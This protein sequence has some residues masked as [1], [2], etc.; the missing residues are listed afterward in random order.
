MKNVD[1]FNPPWECFLCEKLDRKEF[2]QWKKNSAGF[3]SPSQE[4]WIKLSGRE[5]SDGTSPKNI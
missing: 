3:T 5:K 1:P 2:Q 4:W